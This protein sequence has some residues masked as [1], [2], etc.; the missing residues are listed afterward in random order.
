MSAH[1]L[2][3]KVTAAP[4]HISARH[5]TS[6]AD[7]GI[8]ARLVLRALY[9]ELRAYPKPGLVSVID[10]GS[11]ADMDGGTFVRSLFSL[12][13]YFRAIVQ[14][15]AQGAAFPMLQS[16][17]MRAERRMLAATGGVNTHRGAI[18]A[19]GLLA[20]AAGNTARAMD[21]HAAALLGH[22]VRTRWGGGIAR[23]QVH[24]PASHGL[25]VA[26]RYGAGG[27]RAEAAA[28][29]PHVFTVGLPAF[30]EVLMQTSD[31]NRAAVQ[32][33]FSLMALLHDT[34]LLYRGGRGGLVYAQ[35]AARAFLAAGG[36]YQADWREHALSLHREF[37]A[38]RLSPGGSADL[39]AATLFVFEWERTH[40]A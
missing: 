39:L 15:G 21:R 22:V 35:A 20:A 24:A 25:L 11:H 19:L 6:L 30:R 29:F 27:A 32:S 16:L 37:V 5:E 28:G 34:N 9:K 36:V 23:S 13:H 4:L 26:G 2:L 3:H 1:A 18:F 40:R 8:I 10:A 14:A 7:D 12:R 33:F 17:G 31:A 38:R